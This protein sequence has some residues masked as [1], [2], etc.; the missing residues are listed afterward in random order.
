MVAFFS[1]PRTSELKELEWKRLC[2]KPGASEDESWQF[3]ILIIGLQLYDFWVPPPIKHVTDFQD[4]ENVVQ[5]ELIGFNGKSLNMLRKLALWNYWLWEQLF[6]TIWRK[7]AK[8]NRM[9]AVFQRCCC[10]QWFNLC[11]NGWNDPL[12]CGSCGLDS[13]LTSLSLALIRDQCHTC[14]E[15]SMFRIPLLSEIWFSFLLPLLLTIFQGKA[16]FFKRKVSIN[17][18]QRNG[19]R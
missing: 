2:L 18:C 7:A 17:D 16:M 11:E 14:W 19:R 15:P 10:W 4:C 6:L 3:P 1:S 12:L 13:E 5:C 9:L 8:N